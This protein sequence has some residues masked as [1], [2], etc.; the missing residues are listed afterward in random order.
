MPDVSSYLSSQQDFYPDEFTQDQYQEQLENIVKTKKYQKIAINQKGQGFAAIGLASWAAQQIRG[1]LGLRNYTK[2]VRVDAKLL[3]F[4]NYGVTHNYINANQPD[5][6]ISRLVK[7]IKDKIDNG[8]IKVGQAVKEAFEL[9]AEPPLETELTP[10]IRQKVTAYFQRNKSALRPPLW[11]RI[12]NARMVRLPAAPEFGLTYIVLAE[13]EAAKKPSNVKD[14]LSFYGKVAELKLA[15]VSEEFMKRYSASFSNFI[16]GTPSEVR[17]ENQASIDQVYAGLGEMAKV[18]HNYDEAIQFFLAIQDPSSETQTS[19]IQCYLAQNKHAEIEDFL[20]LINVQDISLQPVLKEVVNAFYDN[21]LYKNVIALFKPLK[22]GPERAYFFKM[23]LKSFHALE[24]H[25]GLL[26]YLSNKFVVSSDGQQVEEG[27]VIKNIVIYTPDIDDTAFHPALME[28]IERWEGEF[29]YKDILELCCRIKQSDA[30][31]FFAQSAVDAYEV[32]CTSPKDPAHQIFKNHIFRLDA[33]NVELHPALKQVIECWKKMGLQ[34]EIV[35]LCCKITNASEE[36]QLYFMTTAIDAHCAQEASARSHSTITNYLKR[37]IPNLQT[38]I[39][40]T[41]LPS[42]KSLIETWMDETRLIQ[43]LSDDTNALIDYEIPLTDSEIVNDLDD[44]LLENPSRSKSPN[45][46]PVTSIQGVH[47]V[48]ILDLCTCIKSAIVSEYFSKLEIEALYQLKKEIDINDDRIRPVLKAVVSDWKKAERHADIIAL[49]QGITEGAERVYFV[50][51]AIESY[52]ALND[53][54]GLSNYLNSLDKF[55]KDL[56]PIL[57]TLVGTWKGEEKH[58]LIIDLCQGVRGGELFAFCVDS[59]ITAYYNLGQFNNLAHYISRLD[60]G[61]ERLHPIFKTLTEKLKH[62]GNH[63]GMQEL[64]S[65][66]QSGIEKGYFLRSRIEACVA[67]KEPEFYRDD[68]SLRPMLWQLVEAWQEEERYADILELCTN[69]K[70][71]EGVL[72]FV[73]TAIATYGLLGDY[74]GLSDY[75][76]NLRVIDTELHDIFKKLISTSAKELGHEGVRELASRITEGP[77]RAFFVESAIE[78]Y[79][80]IPDPQGLKAYLK[81]LK[82]DDIDL[83]P[84]FKILVEG[85]KKTFDHEEIID[86]CSQFQA[87]VA[88]GYFR[89]S[90]IEALVVLKKDLGSY[91]TNDDLRPVLIRLVEEWEGEERQDDVLELCRNITCGKSVAFFAKRVIDTFNAYQDHISLADYV[92]KLDVTDPALQD[93]LMDCVR[94]WGDEQHFEDIRDLSSR[95]T[96]GSSCAFFVES[97]IGACLCLQDAEGLQQYLLKLDLKDETLH[98]AFEKLVK[99]WKQL[100]QHKEVLSLCQK[101]KS[102]A[103]A[104]YFLRNAI[105]ASVMLDDHNFYAEND[106]YRPYL[107]EIVKKWIKDGR[108]DDILRLCKNIKTGKGAPYFVETA[109]S[110]FRSLEDQ[111]GLSD[112]LKTL[113]AADQSFH[114]IFKK[115]IEKWI[116][117]AEFDTEKFREILSLA[118]RITEGEERA[119]FVQSMIGAC[120]GLPDAE[121]LQEYLQKLDFKD[122]ALHPAF[123]KLVEAWKEQGQH[124]EILSLCKMITS[125]ARADYFLRNAIEAS[126][127]LNDHKFYAENDDYRPYLQEIVEDWQKA[128]RSDDILSLCMNIKKGKGAAY[129]VETAITTLRTYEVHQP[130]LSNYLKELNSTDESF[131]KAFMKLVQAW[132]EEAKEDREV[133]RDILSLAG[134]ITKGVE[135]A[136]FV[137]STSGAYLGLQ[138]QKGLL[139]HLESLNK[140]DDALHPHFLELVQFWMDSKQYQEVID[141]CVWIESGRNRSAFINQTIRAYLALGQLDTLADYLLL[142]VRLQPDHKNYQEVLVEVIAAWHEAKKYEHIVRL[143]QPNASKLSPLMQGAL[144]NAMIILNHDQDFDKLILELDCRKEDVHPALCQIMDCWLKQ[145]EYTKIVKLFGEMKSTNVTDKQFSAYVSASIKLGDQ[146]FINGKSVIIKY[147]DDYSKAFSHYENALKAMSPEYLKNNDQWNW[148]Q[149][150]IHAYEHHNLNVDAAKLYGSLKQKLPHIT[151]AISSKTEVLVI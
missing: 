132:I 66:I 87:G 108:F 42:L 97:M 60:M 92:Q 35:D 137:A 55:D 71:G 16:S 115:L 51:S 125:G 81:G 133:Y 150:L 148:L 111:Y 3:Q 140:K 116:G 83:Y 2:R 79:L 99:A 105:E 143:L 110:T 73:K 136:F 93:I 46:Q 119:F 127:M 61:D 121:S 142:T 5:L 33:S 4:L 47:W 112:Y 40:D 21:G 70:S 50:D 6:Q 85:W 53:D 95:V 52:R 56:H 86:L 39:S 69:I 37:A 151:F 17:K 75:V 106:A 131:H 90:L 146:E 68:E 103:R 114:P 113:N 101:I 13:A 64:C 54:E 27:D 44:P 98:S 128:E 57:K 123:E 63:K 45:I 88:D 38:D 10:A 49:I 120:L 107:Q 59:A 14:V 109:I 147:R 28:L 29:R 82:K 145:G 78:A 96:T 94:K 91:V 144:I 24:D 76:H 102:G 26:E 31:A 67:L 149:N 41:L 135:R 74:K 48:E 30:I 1:G 22:A 32:A 118:G 34:Q 7:Q 15:P 139:N 124:Q 104:D 77:D 36:N 65:L 117:E 19:I 12:F 8:Q 43:P 62:D 126:V 25:D 84:A 141:F 89:R 23:I 9:L 100:G 122:E 11:S 58:Q 18:S 72:D 134:R 20:I 130:F 129:F 80:G 138:D